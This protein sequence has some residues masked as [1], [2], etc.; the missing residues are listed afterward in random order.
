LR[1]V[2][3]LTRKPNAQPQS[4]PAKEFDDQPQRRAP[5]PKDAQPTLENLTPDEQSMIQSVAPYA[6]KLP[7]VKE[8]I[9]A[10]GK[11]SQRHGSLS[12]APKS[13]HGQAAAAKL[14]MFSLTMENPTP[15]T[16]QR[17]AAMDDG[18]VFIVT[19]KKTGRQ[20]KA[21]WNDGKFTVLE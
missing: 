6:E 9:N 13:A 14:G 7:W 16:N 11:L 5:V 18:E 1:A 15:Y 4:M 10:I 2:D 12:A 20:H 3:R 19:D 21:V 17:P 8:S